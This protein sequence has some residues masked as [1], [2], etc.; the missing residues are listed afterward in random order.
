MQRL[1]V[2]YDDKCGL[3]RRV[4]AWA[5]VQPAIVELVFVAAGEAERLIPGVSKPDTPEELVAV[6]D[7]GSV[8]RGDAAWIMCFYALEDYREWSFRLASPVLRPL[9]RQAFAAL[10]KSR[11][12]V[13][14]FLGLN[15]GELERVLAKEATPA[16]E[17]V[18]G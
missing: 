4:K 16:C 6:G 15:D 1:Y 17:V 11:G 13:S 14:D 7:D 5:G 12:R 2:L 10:S 18:A 9:A 8:Y 3:C